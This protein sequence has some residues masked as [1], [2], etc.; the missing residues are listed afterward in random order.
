MQQPMMINPNIQKHSATPKNQNQFMNNQFNPPNPS[1]SLPYNNTNLV[2]LNT[3]MQMAPPPPSNPYMQMQQPQQSSM[4]LVMQPPPQPQQQQQQQ[5]QPMFFM[6]FGAPQIAPVNP[7]AFTSAPYMVPFNPYGSMVV[8]QPPPQ[9][10][11]IQAQS[12]PQLQ[13]YQ[14]QQQMP[15]MQQ[16]P[17][18]MQQLQQPTMQND[19]PQQSFMSNKSNRNNNNNN[20]NKNPGL[21]SDILLNNT[22][23]NSYMHQPLPPSQMLADGTR[24][25]SI[26]RK[27]PSNHSLARPNDQQPMLMGSLRPQKTNVSSENIESELF[28]Q[29]TA[30]VSSSHPSHQS[31]NS[32]AFPSAQTQP[33][34]Q[35]QQSQQLAEFYK[36]QKSTTAIADDLKHPIEKYRDLIYKPRGWRHSNENLTSLEMQMRR[37]PL[38]MPPLLGSS[39]LDLSER[40][41]ILQAEL[42]LPLE[43]VSLRF[44]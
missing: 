12:Q 20:N 26:L 9:Q 38:L 7:Q 33:L 13:Y 23:S 39:R 27:N 15:H 14:M 32:S 29:K 36:Y 16:Q 2:A 22:N 5:P 4:M 37:P 6:P 42:R 31:Q 11:L 21:A 40:R 35:H 28:Q 19:Q 30:A 25:P 8:P 10:Q 3:T 44:F 41:P 34:Q 17:L 18:Q 24:R 1:T 43:R